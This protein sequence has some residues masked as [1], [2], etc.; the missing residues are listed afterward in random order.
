MSR[1]KNSENKEMIS[2]QLKPGYI[3]QDN[4]YLQTAKPNNKHLHS[5]GEES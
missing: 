1:K 4:F 3:A 2:I 5:R